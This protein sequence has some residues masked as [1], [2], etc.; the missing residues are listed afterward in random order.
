VIRSLE[1]GSIPETR[2]YYAD[3][4]RT[5]MLIVE[6]TG[7]L[8][9]LNDSEST[10][11]FVVNMEDI[12]EDYCFHVLRESIELLGFQNVIRGK[13]SGLKLFAGPKCDSRQA[14]PD[15]L[16]EDSS[17]SCLPLEVKYKSNPDRGDINQAITYGLV[18][19]SSKTVL[20]CYSE[21]A[22]RAGWQYMGIVGS[23]VEV[24]VYRVYLG[25]TKIQFEEERFVGSI[26]NM[27]HGKVAP[28]PL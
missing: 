26:A 12:F 20:V 21:Q 1:N 15:I 24:W 17:G 5:A 16:I 2:N 22:A 28:E 14:E 23:R 9:A 11:A 6:N 7:L 3:V 18:C 19:N 25:S 13:E 8:P 4:C 27:L 10:L